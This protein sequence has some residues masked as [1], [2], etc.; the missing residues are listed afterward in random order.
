[1]LAELQSNIR[2]IEF[3]DSVFSSDNTLLFSASPK[4][5]LQAWQ[6]T[7]GALVGQW[8]A[9]KTPQRDRSSVINITQ[10]KTK[11]IAIITSDGVYQTWS[12]S[13]S[14]SK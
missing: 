11:E 5:K 10:I 4:Q 6:A 13:P 7:D 1:M 14:T 8:Q 2:F 3:N 9:F 12:L